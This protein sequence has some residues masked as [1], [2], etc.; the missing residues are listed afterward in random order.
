MRKKIFLVYPPSP[1]LN[2]EDRCQ[3]P[4]KDL[5]II[6]PLPPTDLMYL[7]GIAELLNIEAKIADYS[8]GGDFKKDLVKFKPDYIVV[9]VA[10][11]TFDSDLKVL[12]TAKKIFPN[13]LTIAKGA[14]FLTCAKET[15][16]DN[17]YIDIIII[18]EA[19]ETLKEILENKTYKDIA[20]IYYRENLTIKYTGKRPFI[21]K[22]DEL[23][24]PARHLVNNKIYKRPD[25][26]KPQAV[27]KVSRGCPYHCF[28]CLATPVSG[29]FVRTRSP[30]N[31]ILEL[32]ECINRYKITNFVFWSDIFTQDRD[33]VIQLC[34]KILEENL[35]IVWSCNTR[36]DTIDEELLALMHEA[37][38]R[39]VS[40]GVESGS[41]YILDKIN[42]KTTIT[43]IKKCF[44]MLKKAKM[45]TYAYFVIGL[46]WDDENTIKQT[47]DFAIDLD[48]DFVSFYTAVPLPGTKFYSYAKENN[49]FAENCS[50]NGAYYN[51]VVKTHSIEKERIMELHK[52]AVKKF[53]LRPKYI[54][55]MILKIRSFTE[56]KN[57]LFAGL[58]IL[59]G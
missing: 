57:Y 50:Y 34:N 18:G 3:Q 40:V 55:K 29:S 30:E 49:L 2:R 26:S 43:E 10:M 51:P 23:P 24:F 35:K 27:I 9:N 12:E 7:A 48:P 46:P 5:F 15:I 47:V 19:E 52:F 59:L 42:K 37:G 14:P 45:K 39:L 1:V 44:K 36:V 6:P 38:C 41:Q 8:L 4:I 16:Q 21:S 25:N 58:S 31:I 53:Y 20:G 54:F 33:W 28:F 56:F 22:L 13:I 32:K 11:P 17:S